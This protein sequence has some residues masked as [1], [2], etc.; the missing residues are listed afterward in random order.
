VLLPFK[1]Y[2]RDI[3]LR[4]TNPYGIDLRSVKETPFVVLQ[5]QKLYAFRTCGNIL[6]EEDSVNKNKHANGS[7]GP[8]TVCAGESLLIDYQ[9]QQLTSYTVYCILCEALRSI[10]AM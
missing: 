2:S 3:S 7:L 4:I 9:R 1:C 10:N 8:R 6:T 5:Q